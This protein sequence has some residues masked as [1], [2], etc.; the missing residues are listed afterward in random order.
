[1][2]EWN[3][4]SHAWLERENIIYESGHLAIHIEHVEEEKV[5]HG[6]TFGSIAQSNEHVSIACVAH[7]ELIDNEH[8]ERKLLAQDASDPQTLIKG[9]ISLGHA[10]RNGPGETVLVIELQLD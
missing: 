4:G 6:I 2:S 9:S 8:L 3:V 7:G 5:V 10:R 1:M